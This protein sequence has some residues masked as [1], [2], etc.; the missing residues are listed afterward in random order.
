MCPLA[1]PQVAAL[2]ATL[3]SLAAFAAP[4][5]A[6]AQTPPDTGALALVNARV[7]DARTGLRPG[8]Y[9][10]LVRG[11]TI[12]SVERGGAVPPGVR[13]VDVGGRFVLPGLIDAHT[14]ITSLAAARRALESGVTT[15][16][17]AST[18][19]FQD[20][21]L[22]E[23]VRAGRLAGPDVLAA[24]VFVTP[25]LGESVLADP[26]LA[27]LAGGVRT[28]EELRDLVGVNV[29]RGVDWIKTRGTERAGL[30]NTDPRKQT[31]TEAQLRAVVQAAGNV[32][33]M[34][35]AHGDE[36]AYAAVRA[37][38]RSIEHGT[39]LSD[40]TLTLMKA[41]GTWL[42]PTYVTVEDLTEP[43]GDYDDPVLTV[44]GRH[45]L[46]RLR[47]TIQRAH[48]M[49]VRIATGVDTS[50]G[51]ESLSR[52]AHECAAFVALGMTPL[53]ALRTATTGA[54][55]LLDLAGK[56]GA[57][58]PGL[59]ADLIV[60]ERNP[61]DDIAAL[62]DVLVVVSNGRLALTRVP[63]ALP[64]TTAGDPSPRAVPER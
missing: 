17:S 5:A 62:Q 33:V 46:P 4:A 45:M 42:V 36:G 6:P 44:R 34:V 9:T 13:V 7:L 63:F 26:A 39:Y 50:Y 14:H 64:S 40:S 10:V 23:L 1:R 22:R 53:E 51:P 38:A 43:G 21:G 57:V 3:A 32:P 49:G 18:G 2:L 52:V 37:G 15:V 47:E 29:R 28:P 12:A 35:H 25:E 27:A 59:E 19:N 24:G 48:R 54:A 31:Y 55:E 60:V 56:T 58:A 20:V 11:R 41:R 16:R 30:P 61:L 8:S